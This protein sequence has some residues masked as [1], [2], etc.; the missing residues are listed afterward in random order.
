MVKKAKKNDK[1]LLLDHVG[2]ILR[3]GS[4]ELVLLEATG[5]QVKI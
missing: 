5:V 4:G 1:I 2:I 3:Y